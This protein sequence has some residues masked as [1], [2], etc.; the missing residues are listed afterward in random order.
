MFQFNPLFRSDNTRIKK[1]HLNRKLMT[2]K[3]AYK[4]NII[5]TTLVTVYDVIFNR[6]L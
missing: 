6:I 3:L 2:K 1:S 4:H 5:K